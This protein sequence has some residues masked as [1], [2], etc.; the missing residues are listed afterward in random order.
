MNILI[1][2]AC[3]GTLS[4]AVRVHLWLRLLAGHDLEAFTFHCYP[5][6]STENFAR[7]FTSRTLGID[8]T[9]KTLSV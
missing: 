2:N 3:L 4:F 1:D 8:I 9:N 7:Q 5:P 6:L